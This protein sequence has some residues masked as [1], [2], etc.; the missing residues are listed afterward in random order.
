L[1]F[2]QVYQS[3][4]NLHVLGTMFISN[5][6]PCH[7]FLKDVHE[8]SMQIPSQLAGSHATVRTGLW[9]PPDALQ[10]LEAS[11]LKMSGL[12]GNTLWTLGQA[13]P[14]STRSWILV[15]T[16]WEVSAVRLDNVATRS[17]VVQHFKNILGFFYKRGKE[18]QWRPSG[19]SAKPSGRGPDMGR[20]WANLE[21]GSRRSS[22]CSN[23]LS[24]RS[25]A[26][27]QFWV[28]L[29]FL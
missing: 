16:I 19:S 25:T 11:E 1:L 26:R 8:D 2:K 15:D 28:E 13:S 20:I 22:G 29:G 27:V 18:L 5:L 9:R 14:I 21:G 23:L 10:C 17:D 3:F 4:Q 24:G 7:K 12:Q 6:V